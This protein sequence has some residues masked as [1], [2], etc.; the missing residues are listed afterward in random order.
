MKKIKSTSCVKLSSCIRVPVVFA[1]LFCLAFVSVQTADAIDPSK[2]PPSP[3]ND[4]SGSAVA[5]GWERAVQAIGVDTLVVSEAEMEAIRAEIEADYG[6]DLDELRM[7]FLDVTKPPY[8][9]TP[10]DWNDDRNAIQQA[11]YDAMAYKAVCYFPSG[12]YR[13]TGQIHCPMPAILKDGYTR[14]NP[15]ADIFQTAGYHCVLVGDRSGDKPEIQLKWGKFTF[16][17]GITSEQEHAYAKDI[18][19]FWSVHIE[20]G[21]QDIHPA[22]EKPNSNFSHRLEYVK[23]NTHTGNPAASGVYMWGAQRCVL[24]DVEVDASDSFAGIRGIPGSGGMMRGVTVTGGRFG[25]YAAV[26][27]IGGSKIWAGGQAGPVIVGVTLTGQTENNI[28]TNQVV[29]PVTIVGA[30]LSISGSDVD[31]IFFVGDRPWLNLLDAKIVCGSGSDSNAIYTKGSV[32]LGSVYAYDADAFVYYPDN[33]GQNLVGRPGG[34]LLADAAGAANGYSQSNQVSSSLSDNDFPRVSWGTDD[35]NAKL[36]NAFNFNGTPPTNLVEKHWPVEGVAIPFWNDGNCINIMDAPYNAIPNDGISD[37]WAIQSALDAAQSSGKSVFIP[38]GQ[39]DMWAAFNLPE[40]VSMFGLA[41]AY[42]KIVAKDSGNFKNSSNPIPFMSTDNS[43][44]GTGSISKLSLFVPV[45][46]ET[47]TVVLDGVYGMKW[48]LGEDSYVRDI[49]CT[50]Q[51][52]PDP[53]VAGDPVGYRDVPWIQLSGNG[54]G[55]WFALQRPNYGDRDEM[56]SSYRHMRMFGTSQKTR[57]YAL[58]VC[59]RAWDTPIAIELTDADNVTVYGLKHENSEGGS[60]TY[61]S[62]A[63]N[64]YSCDNLRIFG[65]SGNAKKGGDGADGV[66]E[67]ESCSNFLLTNLCWMKSINGNDQAWNVMYDHAGSKKI[68]GHQRL[69]YY[70]RGNPEN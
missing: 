20:D 30:D 41:S 63:I 28:Y 49:E 10:D 14:S 38:R 6:G 56:T 29:G 11:V 54:G 40:D 43:A 70:I 51:V 67:L 58:N 66:I 64:A 46:G 33:T 55:R 1:A 27:T 34:W 50:Y 48:Q 32:Y 12:T 18:L 21:N 44:V 61:Y 5:P 9:A 60:P 35:L 68:K 52:K 15:R 36:G 62:D 65:F 4:G 53:N 3:L 13:I 59:E 7:G 45:F 24:E 16:P 57:F 39:W 17:S 69:V 26:E 8:G 31:N 19:H 47:G 42:S 2:F 37:K 23:I 22:Y 25:I